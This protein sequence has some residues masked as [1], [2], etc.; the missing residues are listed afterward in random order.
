MKKPKVEAEALETGEAVMP[1]DDDKLN[2]DEDYDEDAE[3]DDIDEDDDDDDYDDGDIHDY[4]QF[5]NKELIYLI[6]FDGWDKPERIRAKDFIDLQQIIWRMVTQI[7]QPYEWV[8][9]N[10]R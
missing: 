4:D 10:Y 8:I 6:M 7:G 1:Q 5:M 9:R 3:V 2:V